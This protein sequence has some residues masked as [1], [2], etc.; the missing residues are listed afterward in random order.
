[1]TKMEDKLS[2]RA[3]GKSKFA[4]SQCNHIF[5][6]VLT[7]LIIINI[8]TYRLWEISPVMSVHVSDVP[9]HLHDI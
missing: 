6:N 1:M 9:H 7:N 2:E 4:T 8:T 3:G 5:N